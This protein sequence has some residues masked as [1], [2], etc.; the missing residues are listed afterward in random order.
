[1]FTNQSSFITENKFI[2]M[3]FQ[4]QS[5]EEHYTNQDAQFCLQS[6][7]QSSAAVA[8]AAAGPAGSSGSC[9]S[10]SSSSTAPHPAFS[11]SSS[12]SSSLP[13]SSVFPTSS[14]S[15]PVSNISHLVRKRPVS[16][17]VQ[18]MSHTAPSSTSEISAKLSGLLTSIL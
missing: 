15:A 11:A 1:M 13:S 3:G 14:S 17:P 2:S 6:M 9:D 7:F 10:S 8:A 12:S 5:I 16:Q 18:P 4:T